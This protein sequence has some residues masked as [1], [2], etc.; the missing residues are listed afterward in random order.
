MKPAHEDEI[1]HEHSHE[2]QSRGR[3]GVELF[4]QALIY[5]IEMQTAH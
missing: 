3:Q 1:L 5:T 4:L 2:M